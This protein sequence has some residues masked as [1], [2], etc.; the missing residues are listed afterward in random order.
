MQTLANKR[1]SYRVEFA[2]GVKSL[3]AK[4]SPTLTDSVVDEMHALAE[5]AELA[6]I[7]SVVDFTEG[8][9]APPL[10]LTVDQ[11]IVTYVIDRSRKSVRVI[12]LEAA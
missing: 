1:T 6:P 5:L 10:Y 8:Y 3:L 4:L 7:P 12:N 11:W 9:N 2:P